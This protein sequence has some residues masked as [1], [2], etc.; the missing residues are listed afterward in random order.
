MKK[1]VLIAAEISFLSFA[2]VKEK[3][4]IILIQED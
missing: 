2:A 1:A 3:P 4:N